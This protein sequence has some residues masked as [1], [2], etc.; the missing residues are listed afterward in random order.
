MAAGDES[1]E[2]KIGLGEKIWN[3]VNP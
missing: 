3:A 1:S 2:D